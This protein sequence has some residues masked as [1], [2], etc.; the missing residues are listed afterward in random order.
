[1]GLISMFY[2]LLLMIYIC[3]LICKHLR[4]S[5]C[6]NLPYVGFSDGVIVLVMNKEV[7]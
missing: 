3:V 2:D 1:M 7:T 4:F 5:F 6:R